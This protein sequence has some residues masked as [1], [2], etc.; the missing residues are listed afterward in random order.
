MSAPAMRPAGD[1]ERAPL[2]ADREA[3]DA[4]GAASPD[5]KR[6]RKRVS[7]ALICTCAV[8]LA[9]VI[10]LVAAHP[11]SKRK[12]RASAPTVTLLTAHRWHR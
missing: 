4:N 7:V 1:P 10:G 11:H 5:V 8:L 9:L 3:G 6:Q 12:Q 2:L